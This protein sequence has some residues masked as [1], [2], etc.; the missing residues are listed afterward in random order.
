M[1]EGQ[2]SDYTGFDSVSRE[3]PEALQPDYAALDK[4]YDSQHVRQELKARGV[5]PVVPSRSCHNAPIPH[6][7][8]L[9]KER[10]RIERFFNKMK[11]FRRIATRYDKLASSFLAFVHLTAAFIAA[12]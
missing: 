11:H 1:S 3:L 10:N 2:Q 9:Y 8:A 6:N 12:R 4:G 5:I 7:E